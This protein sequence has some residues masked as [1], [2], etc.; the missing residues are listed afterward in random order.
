[1]KKI[2]YASHL[3]SAH[4]NDFLLGVTANLPKGMYLISIVSDN[5]QYKLMDRII[6]F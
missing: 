3:P 2:V 1:L 6:K 5:K 4:V